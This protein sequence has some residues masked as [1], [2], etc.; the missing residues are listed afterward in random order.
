MT[1]P[2]DLVACGCVILVV[3]L[4]GVAVEVWSWWARRGRKD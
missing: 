3:A 1:A 4:A 2:N